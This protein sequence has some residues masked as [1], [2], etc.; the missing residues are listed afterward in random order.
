MGKAKNDYEKGKAF[1]YIKQQQQEMEIA[2]A[3][4]LITGLIA[5]AAIEKAKSEG[6]EKNN[7]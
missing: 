7:G 6:A 2:K 4:L 1:A 5:K 3:E